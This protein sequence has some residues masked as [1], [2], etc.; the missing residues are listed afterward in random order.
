MWASRNRRSS[1]DTPPSV[2]PL[3]GGRRDRSSHRPDSRP[4]SADG[5]PVTFRCLANPRCAGPH[6]RHAGHPRGTA[7]AARRPGR[8]CAHCGRRA[9]A[10]GCSP[11]CGR[12]D[13]RPTAGDRDHRRAHRYRSPRHGRGGRKGPF[14]RAL[15]RRVRRPGARGLPHCPRGRYVRLLRGSVTWT[16]SVSWQD[17]ASVRRDSRCKRCAPS[18]WSTPPAGCHRR[19]VQRLVADRPG[20]SRQSRARPRG[21]PNR[22]ARHTLVGKPTGQLPHGWPFTAR[23]WLRGDNLKSS[24]R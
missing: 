6:A 13:H 11:G 14:Q 15:P 9:T 22:T 21:D 3:P 16:R 19:H 20:R 1:P 7:R 12:R 17:R 18:R 10:P 24:L 23:S 4:T 2:P 5:K 8:R